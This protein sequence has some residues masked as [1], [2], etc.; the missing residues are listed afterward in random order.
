MSGF[1]VFILIIIGGILLG[2]LFASIKLS[3]NKSNNFFSGNEISKKELQKKIDE[4][5]KKKKI[6]EERRKEIQ[7]KM[8]KTM[9]YIYQVYGLPSRDS[10]MI[11]DYSVLFYDDSQIVRFIGR[12]KGDYFQ[13]KYSDLISVS[14]YDK[15][16]TY[17]VPSTQTIT[18]TTRTDNKNMLKRAA[19]GGI[20]FGGVGALAGA[21]TARQ[22]TQTVVSPGIGGYS[23]TIEK[24][25]ITILTKNKIHSRITSQ[26]SAEFAQENID[27]FNYAINIA[28]DNFKPNPYENIMLDLDEKFGTISSQIVKEQKF[29][30]DDIMKI[31]SLNDERFEKIFLQLSKAKIIENRIDENGYSK[32][33]VKNND[34]LLDIKRCLGLF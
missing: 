4:E 5:R 21:T 1:V 2:V 25:I 16:Q 33:L 22:K 30:K 34:E 3:T 19:V 20:L 7:D 32:V 9:K 6:D 11:Y 8:Q 26:V 15:S 31:H 10:R 24:F 27:L 18:S 28:D 29:L 17:N 23:R 14:V 13:I 12:K